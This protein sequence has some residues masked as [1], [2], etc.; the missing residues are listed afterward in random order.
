MQCNILP[1]KLQC[2][3]LLT[4][5][6]HNLLV[7]KLL[8]NSSLENTQFNLPLAKC[9]AI[10]AIPCWKNCNAISFWLNC[11]VINHWQKCNA[12]PCWKNCSAIHPW[13]KCSA[14]SNWQKL[15]CN[16]SLVNTQLDCWSEK[17]HCTLSLAKT[18]VTATKGC[19]CLGSFRSKI[20]NY[21]GYFQCLPWALGTWPWV[22]F[23]IK[24][25]WCK[26]IFRK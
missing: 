21:K 2:N 6:H 15:Q 8:C 14:I 20:K 3:S 10:G 16:S 7:T 5:I 9:S 24:R 17:M 4:R 19:T 18:Q 26:R 11:S 1:T 22:Q 12:I 13:L 25:R 23:A